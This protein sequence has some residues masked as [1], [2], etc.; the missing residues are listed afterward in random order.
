ME[1]ESKQRR[2]KERLLMVM[3]ECGEEHWIWKEGWPQPGE[4][5]KGKEG[6]EVKGGHEF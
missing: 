5:E 3:S 4:E 6:V 1:L 2:E